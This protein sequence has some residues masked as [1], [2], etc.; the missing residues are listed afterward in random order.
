[1]KA[2]NMRL[3]ITFLSMTIILLLTAKVTS[4]QDTEGSK[5]DILKFYGQQITETVTTN[6]LLYFSLIDNYMC[7]GAN[8]TEKAQCSCRKS[9]VN[10]GSCCIDYFWN[11]RDTWSSMDEYVTYFLSKQVNDLSCQ[12]IA[13]IEDTR[14]SENKTTLKMSIIGKI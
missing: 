8:E 10:Q 6:P 3:F 7:S 9:C 11:N 1:M 12:K 2:D 14:S 5:F 4:G 13:N